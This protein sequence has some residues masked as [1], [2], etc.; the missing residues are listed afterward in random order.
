[1]FVETVTA[2]RDVWLHWTDR[3]RLFTDPPP[4]L[5]SA[6]GWDAGDGMITA[7][8]VW[9]SA[10]AVGDFFLERVQPVLEEEGQPAYKPVRHGSAVA[11]Y[12]RGPDY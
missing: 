4:A 12:F 7:V 8:N 9:D 3:L 6:V 1:M 5:V 10:S 11:A 2:P